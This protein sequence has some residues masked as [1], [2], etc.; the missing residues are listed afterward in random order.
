MKDDKTTIYEKDLEIINL[1]SKIRALESEIL[2]C[3][4]II[5]DLKH[6]IGDLLYQMEN[7]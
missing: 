6:R 7:E 2:R 5:A 4:A 3:N 1:K